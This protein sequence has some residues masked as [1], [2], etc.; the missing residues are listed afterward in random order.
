MGTIL[1]VDDEPAI[2]QMLT[3]TLIGDGH[4]C[5]EAADADAA[6]DAVSAGTPDLILLD[7]ML[8]G[9]SGVDFARRLKHDPK[10]RDIPIIMLS[11]KG[12][13]ADK[14]RALDTG[15]DDYITKPFSTEELLARI[16]AVIRRATSLEAQGEII[17]VGH[18]HLD[19]AT[20]RVLID[21]QTIELSPTEFRLLHFFLTHRE[22]VHTR[23]QLLDAVWGSD[24]YVDE[25]T[26]DVH[27]RRLR[28]LLTPQH[29]D[30]YVQT[31]RGVGYRFSV[32]D[33]SSV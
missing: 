4:S 21:E 13:E 29:C 8:P 12:D 26:V 17:D 2:R 10:T 3:F 9:I 19:A 7:W 16:R 1:I 33:D 31:V 24:A 5:I 14:V 25:R 18:L 11:A 27:I 6:H 32:N 15:A 30:D 20:H 28:K 22:R 23:G